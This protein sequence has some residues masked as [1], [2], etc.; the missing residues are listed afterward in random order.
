M[1]KKR[2]LSR[3]DL[4]SKAGAATLAESRDFSMPGITVTHTPVHSK[5]EM[6]YQWFGNDHYLA[7]H[8]IELENAELHTDDRRVD[9]R[10]NLRGT[11]TFVPAGW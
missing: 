7:L 5:R 4:S 6:A 8:E 1:P 11:F 3:L 9:R 2:L 10:G